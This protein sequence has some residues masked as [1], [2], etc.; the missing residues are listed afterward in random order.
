VFVEEENQKSKHPAGDHPPEP[1][2]SEQPKEASTPGN[3]ESIAS[4]VEVQ[5]LIATGEIDLDGTMHLIADRARDVANATGA[6]IGLLKGSELVYRAGSGSAAT[7]IGRRVMAILSVSARKGASDEILRVENTETDARIEAAICRQLGAKSLLILPIY[8]ARAI[9]G[10]L[11]VR[12][13]EAHAFQDREV[14]IYHLM[15]GLVGEAMSHAARLR[16]KQALAAEPSNMRPAIGQTPQ[17]QK[18]GDDSGSIHRPASKHGVRGTRGGASAEVRELL[19][20]AARLIARAK[21][22]PFY[23]YRWKVAM[24][25]VVTVLGVSSW[26]VYTEHRPVS[27]PLSSAVPVSNAIEPQAPIPAKLVAA[28]STLMP[29]T[30]PQR[31]R[32]GNS[33]VR[34]IGEDVT[35]R[36]FAVEPAVQRKRIMNNRVEYIGKDVTVRYLTPDSAPV[37]PARSVDAK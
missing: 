35:V 7:H 37:L 1:A 36:Y 2:I 11:E 4:I 14:R 12:F 10:V 18:V 32:V 22:V 28:R 21:R 27:R 17:L 31:I 30:A 20:G 33:Q 5:R 6:A 19:P 34:Y 15:A 25:A 24:T 29:R 13:S 9:A 8:Y 3:T 26:I 23:N 16:Q